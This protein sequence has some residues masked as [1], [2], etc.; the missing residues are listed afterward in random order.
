ME[1][2]NEH[3]ILEGTERSYKMEKYKLNGKLH[4]TDGPAYI[5][6]H[7]NELVF[8]QIYCLNNKIHR[9]DGPA[10]ILYDMWGNKTFEEYGLLDIVVLQ[11]DFEAP[12]FIDSFIL[13]NS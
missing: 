12:G 13:E 11:K 3:E 5:E 4:R 1:N 10:R 2:Y 7:D 9:V 8:C 6:Y